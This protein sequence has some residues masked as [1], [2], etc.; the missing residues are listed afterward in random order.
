MK[1][2]DKVAIITGAGRGIGRAIARAFAE[3]GARVILTA[4]R[5]WNEIQE[6]AALTGGTAIQADVTKTEEVDQVVQTA[7]ETYGRID[8][9][10][11]NAAR[12]MRF[13]HE[14]F[15]T[16]P[17]LFWRT[18]PIVWRKVMDTNINGVFLMTRA[19]VPHLLQQHY[20]RIINISINQQTM[21]RK[22]FSPYGPSKAALEAMSTIWA[23]ELEGTGI[24]L[25]IL[26]PGGATQTGMVPSTLPQDQLA[27]L[28]K[29]EVMAPA[30]VYLAS[31]E[32]AQVHGKRIV[33]IEWNKEQ[34]DKKGTMA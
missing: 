12:G 21:V 33:A 29:P 3:E 13:V 4:A 11:N 19:V 32:A 27:R 5:H 10:V 8:I 7:L 16:A 17:A 30:A 34:K 18:D 2:K 31:E 28:L 25:N 22:G 15:M 20:G 24:T 9:L 1:L 26:L 6:A 23:K 14:D